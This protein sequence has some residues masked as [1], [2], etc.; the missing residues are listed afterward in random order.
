MRVDVETGAARSTACPEV[1]LAAAAMIGVLVARILVRWPFNHATRGCRHRPLDGEG[2]G[3]WRWET[4]MGSSQPESVR[5]LR[6]GLGG[7]WR[8]VGLV[9]RC[10]LTTHQ[11][12]NL[13][14]Y[15]HIAYVTWASS[16]TVVE[17]SVVP[18][19][20]HHYSLH[21]KECRWQRPAL[22]PPFLFLLLS[23]LL[24]L[25]GCSLPQH[26]PR[27]PAPERQGKGG[28]HP[29]PYAGANAAGT[30]NRG[31]SCVRRVPRVRWLVTAET[32]AVEASDTHRPPSY[33]QTTP[34]PGT[35]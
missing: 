19:G 17:D 18:V 31:C 15:Q 20:S 29:V 7:G 14:R 12:S 23:L 22:L 9:R 11:V 13:H 5:R 10:P 33:G 6:F 4:R 34:S 32:P 25:G 8:S 3:R 2:N 35:V 1:F 24:F 16:S 21:G 28:T 26:P 30:R 27:R